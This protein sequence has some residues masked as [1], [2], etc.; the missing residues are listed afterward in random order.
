MVFA[1]PVRFK[2]SSDLLAAALAP[3]RTLTFMSFVA[4][5]F[6]V[7]NGSAVAAAGARAA[8]DCGVV[9]MSLA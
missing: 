4:F 1:T 6:I 2:F 3:S 8:A 9:T 7:A 5:S